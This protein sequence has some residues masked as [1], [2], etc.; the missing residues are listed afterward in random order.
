MLT[1]LQL[2]PSLPNFAIICNT[3]MLKYKYNNAV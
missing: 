3:C 1:R 2:P